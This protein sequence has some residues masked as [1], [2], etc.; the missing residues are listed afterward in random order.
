MDDNNDMRKFIAENKN[1]IATTAHMPFEIGK[2]AVLTLY[3]V[4]NH[5]PYL[6]EIRLNFQLVTQE[7]VGS[8][9]GFAG[10]HTASFDSALFAQQLPLGGTTGGTTTAAATPAAA[11]TS[12][13]LNSV[14][15]ALV[16]L[17]VLALVGTIIWAR[18][19]T[20][21]RVALD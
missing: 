21:R 8:D 20:R 15:I 4:V 6:K 12:N 13:T 2:A 10:A 3:N 16:I 7:N 17:L 18:G 9:P 14:L 19:A 11:Q 5:K 1:L